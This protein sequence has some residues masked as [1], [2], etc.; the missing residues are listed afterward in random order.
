MGYG[1]PYTDVR[2]ERP[3]FWTWIEGLPGIIAI[4]MFPPASGPEIEVTF[5]THERATSGADED[6]IRAECERMGLNVLKTR[7]RS[8]IGST[9]LLTTGHTIRTGFAAA[10][11]RDAVDDLLEGN[12]DN[13][14]AAVTDPKGEGPILLNPLE[15]AAILPRRAEAPSEGMEVEPTP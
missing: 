12:E 1:A 8:D 4:D 13:R 11:I 14:W 5:G 9:V 10:A 3:R 15:I 6:Y 7:Q 2:I